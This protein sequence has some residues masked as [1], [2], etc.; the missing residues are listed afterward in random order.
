MKYKIF[1]TM[2]S[3]GLLISLIWTSY[4]NHSRIAEHQK[5]V[6]SLEADIRVFEMENDLLERYFCVCSNDEFVRLIMSVIEVESRGNPNA[7]YL[8]CNGLM[9]IKNGTFEPEQ[10]VIDGSKILAELVAKSVNNSDTNT[11]ATDI[12]HR[13]LTSYNRG[14]TGANKYKA[15][16]GTF[17]TDYS[18]KVL[19]KYYE[20]KK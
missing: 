16:T 19:Q 3:L 2:F 14:W 13:T 9:Q 4:S 5:T 10:N 6:D 7:E 1:I 11:T 15:K 18:K 20:M 8:G 17:T 12:L